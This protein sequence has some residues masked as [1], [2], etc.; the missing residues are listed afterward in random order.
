MMSGWLFIEIIIDFLVIDRIVV[1][2][3]CV[4]F[5]G[6]YGLVKWMWLF[7]VILRYC[8]IFVFG[9]MCLKLENLFRL[10]RCSFMFLICS[11]IFWE[12]V[13]I[14]CVCVLDVIVWVL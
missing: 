9:I 4:I 3:E 1:N 6:E 11:L 10:M 2:D 12:F 13:D 5:F 14:I 8:L 7:F